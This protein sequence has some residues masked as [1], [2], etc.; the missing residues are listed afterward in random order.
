MI[1]ALLLPLLL[2]AY[3]AIEE[4]ERRA[5]NPGSSSWRTRIRQSS[6]GN[7]SWLYIAVGLCGTQVARGR[8]WQEIVCTTL[9]MAGCALFHTAHEATRRLP[10]ADLNA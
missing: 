6:Q 7:A 1:F 5:A 9:L 8:D 3:L 10:Q 2:I 4:R